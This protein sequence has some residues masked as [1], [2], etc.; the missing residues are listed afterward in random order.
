MHPLQQATCQF[1]RPFDSALASILHGNTGGAVSDDVDALSGL[2]EPHGPD[3]SMAVRAGICAEISQPRSARRLRPAV[4]TARC[5]T[6]ADPAHVADLYAPA[7][8]HQQGA[9]R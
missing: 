6:G 2:P 1:T 8:R 4:W 7:F 9:G 5:W 3:D